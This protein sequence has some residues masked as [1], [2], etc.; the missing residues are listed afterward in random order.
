MDTSPTP[1]SVQRHPRRPSNPHHPSIRHISGI[2]S[3]LAGTLAA[4]CAR[5][6]SG[7]EVSRAAAAGAKNAATPRACVCVLRS[8]RD[9]FVVHSLAHVDGSDG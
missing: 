4:E 9:A 1:R 5:G 6:G 8:A 7:E 2:I 3:R